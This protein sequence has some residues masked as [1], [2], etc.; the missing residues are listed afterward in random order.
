MGSSHW[1]PT[2]PQ[3]VDQWNLIASDSESPDAEGRRGGAVLSTEFGKYMLGG[4]RW[5]SINSRISYCCRA[6]GHLA[7]SVLKWD[8]GEKRWQEG[9]GES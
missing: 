7:E 9:Q 1:N 3:D 4:S 8:P 5:Q 2:D 6:D